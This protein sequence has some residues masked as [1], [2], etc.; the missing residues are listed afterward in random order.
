[1]FTINYCH[2]KVRD[3]SFSHTQSKTSSQIFRQS[4]RALRIKQTEQ[5]DNVQIFLGFSNH[6]CSSDSLNDMC[7]D[8]KRFP[9]VFTIFLSNRVSSSE[10]MAGGIL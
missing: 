5:F 1:M 9:D 2:E 6:L 4:V 8:H 10:S 7:F 3:I